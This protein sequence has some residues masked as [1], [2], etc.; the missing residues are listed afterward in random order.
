MEIRTGGFDRGLSGREVTEERGG[1][2]I[3]FD[4]ILL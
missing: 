4:C 2:F 1:R 3:G